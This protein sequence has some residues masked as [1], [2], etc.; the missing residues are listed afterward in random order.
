MVRNPWKKLTGR[1]VYENNWF[2]LEED[3]VVN[4]SG[5][6][7]D[8]GVIR[9]KNRAIGII[10]IDADANTWL[11]GQWRY[12]LNEYAWEIP[13]GGH[14]VCEDPLDGAKRELREET[15]LSA[16]RWSELMRVHTSNSVTD[17]CGIVFVAEGLT[18]GETQFDE[19]E[20]LAI[21]KLPLETDVELVVEGEI[22][23][24][25]SVAGLLKLWH[26]RNRQ[27]SARRD[28]IPGNAK[29]NRE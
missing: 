19:T 27:S 9:F 14:P 7:N 13:M 20:D 2:A 23:D 25:I 22:T 29:E 21:Q 28:S 17:E 15:G 12:T 16:S 10:P 3:R 8:Y 6:Q 18:E 11:V 1:Q 26:L 4:P 5:G 24:A